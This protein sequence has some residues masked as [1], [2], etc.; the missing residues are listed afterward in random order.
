MALAIYQHTRIDDLNDLLRYLTED[1]GYT[2]GVA[3]YMANQ[4]YKDGDLRLTK[5][6]YVGI[7]PQG[8]IPIDA[9]FGH[10]ESDHRGLRFVSRKKLWRKTIYRIAEGCDVRAIWPDPSAPIAS[11]PIAALSPP[12]KPTTPP[13]KTNPI[14]P[15][16]KPKRKTQHTKLID[17]ME[18]LHLETGMLPRDV[19]TDIEPAY[20]NKHHIAVAPSRSAITRAYNDYEAAL[21]G[22]AKLPD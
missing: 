3:V 19:R 15:P 7:K 1:L 13:K 10:L 9:E 20:K 4:R 14:T 6:E 17:L 8:E 16:K 5:V 21:I 18:E 22:T 12:C 11:A 2:K